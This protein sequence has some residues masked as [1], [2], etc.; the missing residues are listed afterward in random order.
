[1]LRV[2]SCVALSL[3]SL[4]ASY[5]LSSRSWNWTKTRIRSSAGMRRMSRMMLEILAPWPPAASDAESS[6]PSS[7]TG[8]THDGCTYQPL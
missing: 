4:S 7:P 5:T 2:L 1:M 6:D 8:T 3:A